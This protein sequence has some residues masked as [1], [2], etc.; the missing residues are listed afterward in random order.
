M[1]SH[2]IT[3]RQV[4]QAAAIMIVA[5]NPTSCS[6]ARAAC[7]AGP[8]GTQ[9]ARSLQPIHE[10]LISFEE[11]FQVVQVKEKPDDCNPFPYSQNIRT[12]LSTGGYA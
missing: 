12:C 3:R 10:Y 7:D 11:A 2:L 5:S 4:L 1:A 6:R 8:K 9:G